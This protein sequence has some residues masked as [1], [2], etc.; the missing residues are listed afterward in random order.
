MPKYVVTFFI[1]GTYSVVVEARS[2]YHA[3]EM[4][5]EE[6]IKEVVCPCCGVEVG[7]IDDE[8]VVTEVH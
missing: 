1:E 2:E 7:E 3:V 8:S 6:R 4:A 5:E